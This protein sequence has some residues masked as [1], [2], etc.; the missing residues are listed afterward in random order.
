MAVSFLD[1]ISTISLLGLLI[2]PIFRVAIR[3]LRLPLCQRM[4][5]PN[6]AQWLPS[7]NALK[8][9]L[10]IHDFEAYFNSRMPKLFSQLNRELGV[11][12]ETPSHQAGNG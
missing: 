3:I 12:P 8:T 7:S 9:I 4:F 10:N 6:L 5:H 2:V 11:F 1:N